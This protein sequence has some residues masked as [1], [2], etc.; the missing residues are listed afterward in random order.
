MTTIYGYQALRPHQE[1]VLKPFL[2]GRD[3]L[4]IIPTGGG[5][6][7]CYI[8][9]A[10]M[11]E[12]LGVVIS[13]LIS[14]IR[15]QVIKL[16]SFGVPAASMDS[17]QT[18]AE[19]NQVIRGLQQS[20][21]KILFISPERLANK[22]FRSFL[23]T[24]KMRFLAV[25][26]AHC[27]S[28]W[29]SDFRPEYRKLGLYFADLPQDIPRLALTATATTKVRHDISHNLKL[30]EPA[31]IIRTPI[32][33]NLEI[34]AKQL[35]A[36]TDHIQQILA[37]LPSSTNQGIIYTFS[38]KNSTLIARLLQQKGVSSASYHAG[39]SAKEREHTLHRFLTSDVAVVVA[40][41]A[42]GLG[43]DKKDIRFV[44]HYG[45][46]PT[47]ESYIQQIGRAGR[48]GMKSRC[49]LFF[50]KRDADTHRYL[51]E[52]NYPKPQRIKRAYE[53]LRYLHDQHPEKSYVLYQDFILE[54]QGYNEAS[55]KDMARLIAILL[56][57][58]LIEQVTRGDHRVRQETQKTAEAIRLKANE[59]DMVNFL[60]H[61]HDRKQEAAKKI[62][63]METYAI[64]GDKGDQVIRRYFDS[65]I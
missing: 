61:Y 57:E 54:Y 58:D 8:V 48:D 63:A 32:R 5:K 2:Q 55:E 22:D 19:K 62:D 59:Q 31:E 7:L 36:N 26:E 12:G 1:A 53:I 45:L 23:G 56:K 24:R 43:I 34:E 15:D 11:G 46:P 41:N 16:R 4:A 50:Q 40:T 60:H 64:S 37:K 20:W 28:E 42:F 38:R 51:W 10:M 13:P 27:V 30:R 9:P 6:S 33:D 65:P 35:K 39:L 18:Y 14:L 49:C 29:G 44:H 17:M 21:I 3:T 47:L 25:D 52:Q